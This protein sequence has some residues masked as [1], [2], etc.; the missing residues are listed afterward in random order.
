MSTHASITLEKMDGTKT[1]IYCH[2]DGYIEYTGVILQLYYNTAEKVEELLKLG[3]LAQIDETLEKCDAYHR[4]YNEELKFSCSREEYN[5]TFKESE[6]AWF[7]EYTTYTELHSRTLEKIMG[8]VKTD[9]CEYN[10]AYLI[11]KIEDKKHRI[12][13]LWK[14]NWKAGS[15]VDICISQ[16]IES[17][18]IANDRKR[19]KYDSW[20]RAYAD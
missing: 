8:C 3:D 16:A 9:D 4:D 19:E 17:V 6:G 18:I 14:D 5:Y 7:V 11:D 15:I 20:Y 13:H 12:E 2:Y 10:H 1:S